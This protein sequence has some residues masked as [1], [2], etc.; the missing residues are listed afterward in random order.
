MQQERMYAQKQLKLTC[1][2]YA[3]QVQ[4]AAWHGA[5]SGLCHDTF[6]P[7]DLRQYDTPLCHV[8]MCVDWQQR[9]RMGTLKHVRHDLFCVGCSGHTKVGTVSRQSHRGAALLS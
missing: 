2:N 6:E 1:N 8:D 3:T 9:L 4:L 5:T 7:V